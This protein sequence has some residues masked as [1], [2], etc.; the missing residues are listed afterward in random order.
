LRDVFKTLQQLLL[1]DDR[2]PQA[3]DL[4][5]Q[6]QPE[7]RRVGV[8]ECSES[9]ARSARDDMQRN[10]RAEKSRRENAGSAPWIHRQRIPEKK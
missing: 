2:L 7:R 9:R 6:R 8:L 4:T 1:A 10:D 5:R 3:I